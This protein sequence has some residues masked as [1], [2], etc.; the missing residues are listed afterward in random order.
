MKHIYNIYVITETSGFELRITGGKSKSEGLVEVKINGT[1]G[2][3]CGWYMTN[4]VATVICRQRGFMYGVYVVNHSYGNTT[5]PVW[6]SRAY[7]HGNE[8]SILDCELVGLAEKPD[9]ACA[10]HEKDIGVKCYASGKL[11]YLQCVQMSQIEY[12]KAH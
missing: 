5:G 12:K 11:I 3:I 10:A 7:C 8:S 9:T 4:K 2:S 1:W 6:I